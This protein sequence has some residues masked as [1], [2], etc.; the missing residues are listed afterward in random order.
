MT[1]NFNTLQE[2]GLLIANASSKTR[3][4]PPLVLNGKHQ[5]PFYNAAE[6]VVTQALVNW[7]YEYEVQPPTSVIHQTLRGN[8]QTYDE[9]LNHGQLLGDGGFARVVAINNQMA[10]KATC[11]P[12]TQRL[13][14]NLFESEVDIAGLPL[15]Y[16]SLGAIGVDADQFEFQGYFVERLF[17]PQTSSQEKLRQEFANFFA[18]ALQDDQD[19]SDTVLSIQIAEECIRT[20]K[21]SLG[22]AFSMLLPI[23]KSIP[24]VL[25][26]ASIANV[27][28]TAEGHISLADPVAPVI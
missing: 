1:T 28:F 22:E 26:L 2:L 4:T 7:T 20:D 23:L 15:V 16:Q 9:L 6:A 5:A 3:G 27:M 25:D 11:C 19:Q 14:A 21:F 24:S 12:A 17:K 13:L 10:L 18:L 8:T